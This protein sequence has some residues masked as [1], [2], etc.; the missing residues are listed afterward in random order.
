M[1]Q[2]K[3]ASISSHIIRIEIINFSGILCFIYREGR[4][5]KREESQLQLTGC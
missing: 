3:Q 1:A 4:S 5:I 2:K